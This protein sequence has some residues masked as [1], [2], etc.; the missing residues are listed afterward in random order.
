MIKVACSI[1]FSCICLV[2]IA[3]VNLPKN[4]PFKTFNYKNSAAEKVVYDFSTSEKK[5]FLFYDPKTEALAE[6]MYNGCDFVFD[7]EKVTI[8]PIFYTGQLKKKNAGTSFPSLI[9]PQIYK[10]FLK[11]DFGIFNL[12]DSDYPIMVFYNEKNELCGFAK[13]VEQVNLIDCD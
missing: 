1:V 11:N 3:Q 13:N 4:M 2:Q 6:A 5:A 12:S 8:F 10:V 9:P 7:K